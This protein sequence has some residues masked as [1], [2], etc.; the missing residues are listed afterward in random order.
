MVGESHDSF[1]LLGEGCDDISALSADNSTVVQG[2]DTGGT[3]NK[4]KMKISCLSGPLNHV[5]S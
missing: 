5:R 3:L 4:I 2:G 1:P